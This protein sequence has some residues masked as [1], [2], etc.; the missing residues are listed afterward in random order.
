MNNVIKTASKWSNPRLKPSRICSFLCSTRWWCQKRRNMPSNVHF[1]TFVF[2]L[3]L[4]CCNLCL[5]NF[6]TKGSPQKSYNKALVSKLESFDLS[7]EAHEVGEA[8]LSRRR[9]YARQLLKLVKRP[10]ARNETG[11]EKGP[12]NMTP[13]AA[14]SHHQLRPPRRK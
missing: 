1:W 13:A 7:A 12:D 11:E 9:A 6:P 10:E 8:R 3:F 2:Y 4:I 5:T 14:S